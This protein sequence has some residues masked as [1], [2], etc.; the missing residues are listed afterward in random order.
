MNDKDAMTL[1]RLLETCA[2][3][4]AADYSHEFPTRRALFNWCWGWE[5]RGELADMLRLCEAYGVDL[6]AEPGS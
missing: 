3:M 5:G 2:R 1:L 4:M 6:E